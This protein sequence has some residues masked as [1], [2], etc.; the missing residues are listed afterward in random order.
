MK[1]FYIFYSYIYDVENT[2]KQ[3]W[4][5]DSIDDKRE[6]LRIGCYYAMRALLEMMPFRTEAEWHIRSYHI[7]S[8]EDFSD[9][10]EKFSDDE[11]VASYYSDERLN[12]FVMLYLQHIT[13][14]T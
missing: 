4:F 12:F 8:T 2:F 3:L 9:E 10:G 1:P 13:F 11:S 6:H 5:I 7:L 14:C